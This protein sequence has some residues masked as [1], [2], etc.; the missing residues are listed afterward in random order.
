MNIDIWKKVVPRPVVMFFYS[1]IF[2]LTLI[3]TAGLINTVS[4]SYQ[5]PQNLGDIAVKL[6]YFTEHKDDYDAIFFGASTTYQEVIPKVFDEL[7]SASGKDV[8]SFNFGI[9]AANIAE[10][11]FYLQKVLVLKPEKLKWIFLDCL[12]NDF[13]EITPTSA[14]NIYW[15]T[16]IQTLENYRIIASSSY[17]LKDKI[18]GFYA[19]SISFIYRWLEIGYFS[20]FVQQRKEKLP[21]SGFQIIAS[22]DKMLQESGY[23]A[24]DWM[25][26]SEEWKKIFQA[27]YLEGYLRRLEQAKLGDF[28]QNN[29]SAHNSYG[30]KII[31]KIV[32]RID[33]FGKNSKNKVESIF[34]IPPTLETDLDH[35]S[36]MRA[37][38][39]GYISTLFA[40]NNP[41]N[42]ATFYELDRRTD[43]RHLNHQGA[44]EF[45]RALAAKFLQHLNSSSNEPYNQSLLSSSQLI[46]GKS[47]NKK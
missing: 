15:H 43:G 45:T 38:D 41:N 22:T 3:F 32:S 34:F 18:G 7:L 33:D 28:E 40:F 23:Y 36:I 35:S 21:F 13:N 4:E 17:S 44:Q 8:K 1:M 24:M 29:T 12:V 19:N 47:Q 20:N 25:Q 6:Q 42:F 11:D 31:Q 14:R 37:Y 39:L 5:N 46:T 30:I 16:P 27:K 26:N 10:L 9:M 2:I